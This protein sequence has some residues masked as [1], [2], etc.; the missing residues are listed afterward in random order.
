MVKFDEGE[1]VSLPFSGEHADLD[2]HA[3]QTILVELKGRKVF[4]LVDSDAIDPA[5]YRVVA[6]AI[7]RLDA[8][9]VGMECFGAPLSWLYG[10]L[11]SKPL[12]RRDDESRRLSA[13]DCERAW[14]LVRDLGCP[15]T[16]IYAMGQEPWMRY[17][18]G[19]E[20][21]P[22]CIQ[23]AQTRNFFDRCREFSVE[24]EQLHISRELLF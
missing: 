24:V 22:G 8:L 14:R 11:L 5:L 17:L 2:I 9:F 1:I 12:S 15:K 23:L 16:F 19:L 7:G 10:P 13:S 20:Y 6:D 3:K 18:M 21:Q 4:F